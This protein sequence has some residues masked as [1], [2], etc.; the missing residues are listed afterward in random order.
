MA[1]RLSPHVVNGGVGSSTS[2][3]TP[4]ARLQAHYYM[5]WRS[6]AYRPSLPRRGA[7]EREQPLV[8][9]LADHLD[10][11]TRSPDDGPL[12]GQALLECVA[13]GLVGTTPSARDDQLGK[14]C[15][16]ERIKCDGCFPLWLLQPR[17]LDPSACV[18]YLAVTCVM[19]RQLA[20]SQSRRIL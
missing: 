12:G 17:C 3:V 16:G 5:Q 14:W 10:G 18:I 9:W 20:E 13:D 15:G 6:A 7:Q 1:V 19:L 4:V 2:H 8:E 11:V